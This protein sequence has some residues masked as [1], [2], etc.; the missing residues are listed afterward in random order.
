MKTRSLMFVFA[1]FAATP[2][3][4]GQ[5]PTT[6]EIVV[7]GV[8]GNYTVNTGL[9]QQVMKTYE[10][11]T[12]AADNR[13]TV[14]KAFEKLLGHDGQQGGRVEV[15][16]QRVGEGEKAREVILLFVSA[17]EAMQASVASTVE[18]INRGEI[19]D[20]IGGLPVYK[21]YYPKYRSARAIADAVEAELTDQIGAIHVD[22]VLNAL[23]VEDEPFIANWLIEEVLPAFDRPTPQVQILVQVVEV[24]K[25]L[26]SQ[27]GWNTQA[28]QQALP[29]NIDVNLGATRFDP[30][31]KLKLDTA[32]ASITGIS[33]QAL[34]AIFDAWQSKGCAKVI[35]SSTLNVVNGEK[36][37][38]ETGLRRP[39]TALVDDGPNK[40]YRDDSVL[41]GVSIEITGT[42]AE[43]GRRLNVV[44]TVNSVIGFSANG[45]PIVSTSNIAT[46]VNLAA[47]NSVV[48]SGLQRTTVANITHG[49]LFK[50]KVKEN[51]EWDV[52]IVVHALN[53]PQ[54]VSP[55][56][57]RRPQQIH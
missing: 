31:S 40:K 37:S 5:N 50:R 4:L 49:V 52:L 24:E 14:E 44:A 27:I 26:S 48:I 19:V 23:T 55:T 10:I 45:M 41:D 42:L 36:A 57:P 12:V 28:L 18:A 38:L 8:P 6:K 20:Y 1:L 47:G 21:V 11:R 35:S 25:G 22:E 7:G 29:S 2:I 43:I 53:A 56:L 3:C 17:T 15:A 32:G 13:S 39:F 30:T 16:S 34:G 51:R 54:E 33:P 46:T 9:S